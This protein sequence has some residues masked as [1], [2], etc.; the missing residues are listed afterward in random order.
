MVPTA[1][2]GE[3]KHIGI[4]VKQK[5]IEDL[6]EKNW[7]RHRR[8]HNR[9]FRL[10]LSG[11]AFAVFAVMSFHPLLVEYLSTEGIFNLGMFSWQPGFRKNIGAC[12][13]LLVCEQT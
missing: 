4:G 1:A 9:P 10:K 12:V 13:V 8:G 2:G 7:R 5:D 3:P 11:S 6:K